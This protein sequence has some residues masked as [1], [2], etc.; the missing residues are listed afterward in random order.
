VCIH[1]IYNI[2][3]TRHLLTIV[4]PIDARRLRCAI[5]LAI[6]LL[7]HS[8]HIPAISTVLLK[9]M[10]LHAE[11]GLCM[12]S[13]LDSSSACWVLGQR[14]KKLKCSQIVKSLGHP[15]A[16]PVPTPCQVYLG[17]LPIVQPPSL[18]AEPIGIVCGRHKIHQVRT[19]TRL[20]E[21]KSSSLWRPSL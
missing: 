8:F 21:S 20:A 13:W 7:M 15:L 2:R 10:C 5:S 3:V 18:L 19:R 16:S 12:V 9:M 17:P 11:L 14:P 6:G 1:S 4:L